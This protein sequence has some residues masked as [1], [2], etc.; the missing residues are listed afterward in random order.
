MADLTVTAAN[1]V[2][3]ANAQIARGTAGGQIG[4]LEP[5][6]ADASD[7]YKLKR[8]AHTNAATA[9]LVGVS[10]HP[11]EAGQPVAY[12][13][14]GDVAVGS[15]LTAAMV[16]VLGSAAGKISP[17]GDLDSSSPNTRYGSIVG[18]A[19]SSSN[20]RIGILNSG[21]QQP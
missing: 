15:I 8:G 1:V 12:I 18:I 13:T 14:G 20:L 21:I 6:Y 2:P 3:A 11:A 10:L 4:T 7:S 9:E 16:Y 5:L 17:S 19:T